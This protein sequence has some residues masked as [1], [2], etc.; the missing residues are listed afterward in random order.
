[1]GKFPLPFNTKRIQKPSDSSR[2]DES[3][4]VSFDDT[5]APVHGTISEVDISI[6]S[7][8]VRDDPA[9]LLSWIDSL[10]VRAKLAIRHQHQEQVNLA[11]R[12]KELELRQKYRDAVFDEPF[13]KLGQLLNH[14]SE[15]SSRK[16]LFHEDS[17]YPEQSY[18]SM[19]F[20]VGNA[21][22]DA[23]EVLSSEPEIELYKSLIDSTRR[24]DFGREK[25]D[26]GEEE[27]EQDEEEEEEEEEEGEEEE[28]EEEEEEVEEEEEEIE[29]DEEEEEEGSDS[30]HHTNTYVTQGVSYHLRDG[31]PRLSDTYAP[32]EV[33][34][35]SSENELEGEASPLEE[36]E[37]SPEVSEEVSEE[38]VEGFDESPEPEEGAEEEH[39]SDNADTTQY[40]LFDNNMF[41]NEDLL[42]FAETVLQS[43]EQ[44]AREQEAQAQHNQELAATAVDELK[45]PSGF[46]TDYESNAN[47]E[48]P[49]PDAPLTRVKSLTPEERS[50]YEPI[51]EI[52]DDG[53]L[54]EGSLADTEAPVP[55]DEQKEQGVDKE[56]S[57]EP[58][59]IPNPSKTFPVFKTVEE[60]DPE[61]VL[62]KLKETES[63]FNI[64]LSVVEELE[65]EIS[66]IR[67][68]VPPENQPTEGNETTYHD[69]ENETINDADNEITYDAGNETTFHDANNTAHD[70]IHETAHAIHESEVSVREEA[71]VYHDFSILTGE[72]TVSG[73]PVQPDIE[74][75]DESETH[76]PVEDHIHDAD[77]YPSP[78][79]ADETVEY[80]DAAS[81][82]SPSSTAEDSAFRLTE[83]I[84][85][86]AVEYAMNAVQDLYE[87]SEREDLL[88]DQELVDSI[89]E[90]IADTL[91]EQSSELHEVVDVELTIG[92]VSEPEETF[93]QVDTTFEDAVELT[94]DAVDST[95]ESEKS[96]KAIEVVEE[97]ENL[98][99]ESPEE[100]SAYSR[101]SNATLENKET[102][103][104]D[105]FE[106]EA[107]ET[108][109]GTGKPGEEGSGTEK[110]EDPTTNGVEDEADES[111]YHEVD[112]TV[113]PSE[114][115][116]SGEPIVEEPQ[117]I[118]VSVSEYLGTVIT[119]G[120]VTPTD[121]EEPESVI[122]TETVEV[123]EPQYVDETET[124]QELLL[125]TNITEPAEVEQ[126]IKDVTEDYGS[127]IPLFPTS[128]T[129]V[130]GTPQAEVLAKREDELSRKRPLE[131]VEQPPAKR[132]FG[133]N[134]FR[135][136]KGAWGFAKSPNSVVANET[137]V[138]EKFEVQDT[139]DVSDVSGDEEDEA[140]SE[141]EQEIEQLEDLEEEF[142]MVK[143]APENSDDEVEELAEIEDEYK[144]VKKSPLGP[145][146][147]VEELADL[148][149][150]YRLVKKDPVG[151][152]DEVEELRVLERQYNELNGEGGEEDEEED[153]E[154][155]DEEDEDQEEDQE[156]DQDEEQSLQVEEQAEIANR[157]NTEDQ[158][159]E[160]EVFKEHIAKPI[161]EEVP[162]DSES[163]SPLSQTE[164]TPTEAE[165]VAA[166]AEATQNTGESLH[167]DQVTK[168]GEDQVTKLEADEETKLVED[169]VTK[170]DDV[171]L[172]D[173]KQPLGEEVSGSVA[174]AI[175]SVS[176]TKDEAPHADEPAESPEDKDDTTVNQDT[177]HDTDHD[178]TV[179]FAPEPIVKPVLDDVPD[180]SDESEEEVFDALTQT[181][182]ETEPMDGDEGNQEATDAEDEEGRKAAEATDDEEHQ[183]SFE[184]P[185]ATV[186]QD[187]DE[188]SVHEADAPIDQSEEMANASIDQ[189]EEKANA[190]IEQSEEKANAHVDQPEEKAPEILEGQ[191]PTRTNETEGEASSQHPEDPDATKSE[192]ERQPPATSLDS[193]E[194]QDPDVT[195]QGHH[196]PV[197][198]SASQ[199][200]NILEY[201]RAIAERESL[202]QTTIGG[203][204][205]REQT[206]EPADPQTPPPPDSP[207]DTQTL[208]PPDSP[209]AHTRSHDMPHLINPKVRSTP[210]PRK[211][212]GRQPRAG[213]GPKLEVDRVLSKDEYED[214]P[215]ARTRSKSPLKRSIR[216]L[217]SEIELGKVPKRKK[218]QPKK[219]EPRRGRRR[220]RHQ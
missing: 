185:E 52:V 197:Q 143:R 130:E 172:E 25:E 151:L 84:T 55:S 144:S 191:E 119:S 39:Y 136:L 132:R 152:D 27:I 10:N 1:M 135:W 146:E 196:Q 112:D 158:V 219:E 59:V 176:P 147:E 156:E 122:L 120:V 145:S 99:E 160:S 100:V 218:S 167:E 162:V 175:L 3:S 12:A 125:P 137:E 73:G 97:A 165:D 68:S 187:G 40:Q 161:L 199:E 9:D 47:V 58:I 70:V 114:S 108:E 4:F 188:A 5:P 157:E 18:Q 184:D 109:S 33:M 192:D 61:E 189:A 111:E 37:E 131:E 107:V 204:M 101:T 138:E 80:V 182:E 48:M 118:E 115:T 141:S 105:Q 96:N 116:P 92:E 86:Q 203:R 193:I 83:Q 81:L 38:N 163:S 110:T 180:V 174:D 155:Q 181:T 23:I 133:L 121:I 69:A 57:P 43:A 212:S 31:R 128:V 216:E 117:E 202:N 142:D 85:Q 56:K 91:R 41:A 207:A 159:V 106:A 164:E 22:D 213:S 220:Q 54:T 19:H 66:G 140:M 206:P 75:S 35:L 32:N 76:V 62:R 28:G 149:E 36:D 53:D 170:P 209:A 13:N 29:Q 51:Q 77:A 45:N 103:E 134:P 211:T 104:A 21:E 126:I 183:E 179:I 71:T 153:Q 2:R 127:E 64:H 82:R 186:E 201:L 88:E 24:Y 200:H 210:S 65:E 14:S 113:E 20:D 178:T 6:E 123:P 16:Q 49:V 195:P 168:L 72:S 7:S 124:A 90:E 60:E 129:L 63:K 171:L 150:E 87:A 15:V 8:R 78:P 89:H 217:S 208:P 42:N 198:R 79:D 94:E 67:S 46:T 98:L 194:K 154:I 166:S 50:A 30:S 44:E 26:E 139:D 214:H 93:A 173:A 205:S 148:E 177:D 34:V 74:I 95:A 190:A 11:R 102:A 17:P 215:A 169:E